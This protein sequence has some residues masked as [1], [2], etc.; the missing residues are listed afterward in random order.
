MPPAAL[1]RRALAGKAHLSDLVASSRLGRRVHPH[2]N[3]R[4]LSLTFAY[5]DSEEVLGDYAEFGVWQGNTFVDAWRAAG[6]HPTPRRFVAFDSF[7]GLPEL[8]GPDVGG[9]FERGQF[10]LS[11]QRFEARL[12]RARMPSENV[13]IVEGFFNDTLAEPD[14]IPLERVAVAWIDC[15]LYSSTV[16]VLDYLTPRL[17]QGAVVLFDDWFCFQGARDKGE[18]KACAEWLGRNPDI[19]LVPWWQ[20]N[21]GGQAFLFRRAEEG[22][23]PP[24]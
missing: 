19:S 14:R 8:A 23:A 3:T 18:A 9:R 4:I 10:D 16:P 21:W 12:R 17:A 22:D 2:A 6:E 15:D 11:R 24:Q 13:R 1:R 7:E 20:F 5:A